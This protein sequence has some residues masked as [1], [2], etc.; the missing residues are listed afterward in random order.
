LLYPYGVGFPA[1]KD[2]DFCYINH[3]IQCGSSYRRFAETSDWLF[4]HYSYELRM[5]NGG[6]AA[7]AAKMRERNDRIDD[8][9]TMLLMDFLKSSNISDPGKMARIRNILKLVQPFAAAIPGSHLAMEQERNRLRSLVN[10][11]ITTKEGHW[12]WFFTQ[13]Q[14]DLHSPLIYDNL[15]QCSDSIS[16]AEASDV[17]TKEQR[18]MMLMK[19]PV[20]P[21]RCWKL[22]QQ[23]FFDCILNGS[24]KPLGGE[25]VD[26]VDKTEFQVKSTIHSHYMLCIKD[27]ILS[28]RDADALS[29]A[30]Q[31]VIVDIVN[32]TVQANSL[33][34]CVSLARSVQIQLITTAHT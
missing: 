7:K 24:S 9:D 34:V 31:K 29:E 5:K 25:V 20:I 16:A 13:A 14:S 15:V 19:N 17:L 8:G 1:G 23:A 33:N 4:T 21:V 12:R 11:P 3:R 10:S 18:K 30:T 6:I 26:W 32:A 2:I 27:P 28:E 22:Q